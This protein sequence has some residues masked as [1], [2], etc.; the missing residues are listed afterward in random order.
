MPHDIRRTDLDDPITYEIRIKGHLSADWTQWFDCL[1][2]VQIDDGETVLT[3]T[4][5]DQ[6]ALHGLLR[7]IR[8]LGVAL[9]SVVQITTSDVADGE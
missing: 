2:I 3:C 1:T 4:V 7:R 8:D 5:C 9:I 6:S